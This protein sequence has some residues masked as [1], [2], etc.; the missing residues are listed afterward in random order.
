MLAP[1]SR[2]LYS[3]VM[4]PGQQ[5]LLL[6]QLYYKDFDFCPY[7]TFIKVESTMHRDLDLFLLFAFLSFSALSNMSYIRLPDCQLN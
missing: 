7:S 2:F 1:M 6:F 3:T 4:R 5:G